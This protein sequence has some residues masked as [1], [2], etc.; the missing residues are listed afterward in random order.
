MADENRH[1]DADTQ[2]EEEFARLLTPS[3]R[4]IYA[5]T[6][7]LLPN[8]ADAEDC[9]QE[10]SLQLWRK[11]D[12]F[13]RTGSFSRWARGFIRK[14]VKNHYRRSRPHYLA[15]DE[16]L[17]DRL[18]KIQ[19]AAQELLELRREWLLE[20]LERLPAADRKLI[21]LYYEQEESVPDTAATTNR[22]PAAIYQ[23][24]RRIRLALFHCVDRHLRREE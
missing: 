23:S 22:T 20:C 7:T 12:E 13:D 24:L 2:K 17:I 4:A 3:Y 6:R 1:D 8:V 15:L 11:F 21:N 18:I 9:V 16:A 5:Y 19:G 14:V 10:V